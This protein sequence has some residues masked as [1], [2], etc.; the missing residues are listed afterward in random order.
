MKRQKLGKVPWGMLVCQWG[1]CLTLSE[2]AEFGGANVTVSRTHTG[3]SLCFQIISTS[4]A[5]MP[6]RAGLYFQILVE[7]RGFLVLRSSRLGGVIGTP[8]AGSRGEFFPRRT[9]NLHSGALRAAARGSPRDRLD[10]GA[11][12]PTASWPTPMRRRRG[13][14]YPA[15]PCRLWL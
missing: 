11:P 2:L 10:Q 3:F 15:A 9:I 4:T 6:N 1:E 5:S 12:G 8:L 13:V 14:T 7:S